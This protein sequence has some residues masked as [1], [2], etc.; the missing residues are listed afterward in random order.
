MAPKLVIW[1]QRFTSLDG[2]MGSWAEQVAGWAVRFGWDVQVAHF[3]PSG[4]PREKA[5]AIACA[6]T[7]YELGESS[8]AAKPFRF[9][10][11]A[12]AVWK[13]RS[14][15]EKKDLAMILF[16]EPSDLKFWTFLLIPGRLRPYALMIGCRTLDD[17]IPSGWWKRLRNRWYRRWIKGAASI[18][19]D[20]ED[21]R[22]ELTRN[23]VP[24]E[25][26]L[27]SYAGID[28]RSYHAGVSPN[29]FW[30]LLEK[31]QI[32]YGDRPLLLYHG[33]IAMDNR[34]SDMLDILS[35]LPEACGVFIGEGPLRTQMEEEARR[36]GVQAW[37]LGYQPEEI[38]ASAFRAADVCLFPL[39]SI[40]AGVSLAV[41]KAMACG[42]AVITNDVADMARLVHHEENG[43]LCAEGDI[44]G[45]TEAVRRLLGDSALRA[46]LGQAACVT[47]ER[48]WGESS[49]E[50][51]YR[52]WFDSLIASAGN[53]AD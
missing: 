46:R 3:R 32:P 17:H 13:M 22:R 53:R 47:I 38:L 1:T 49:R 21:I 36:R 43:L 35:R 44:E 5:E 30:N 25:K 26:I 24:S 28:L 7:L 39:S 15:L 10:S 9:L 52:R 41:P 31:R 33:R 20:G 14:I 12:K 51:E 8:A 48:E 29:P 18:L 23:G 16:G 45:W 6:Y 27:V 40:V 19:V 42:A 37:F 11:M 2:G 34:P 4:L 50:Q